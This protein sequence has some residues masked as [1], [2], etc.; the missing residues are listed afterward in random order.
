MPQSCTTK[1][2]SRHQVW[3]DGMMG[4]E[5]SLLMMQEGSRAAGPGGGGCGGRTGGQLM[6]CVHP[7]GAL[8]LR[9]PS[10]RRHPHQLKPTQHVARACLPSHRTRRLDGA[11]FGRLGPALAWRG[12]QRAR[13]AA[14]PAP[15][16]GRPGRPSWASHRW[17]RRR[18][19]GSGVRGAACCGP[20]DPWDHLQDRHQEGQQG[21]LQHPLPAQCQVSAGRAWQRPAPGSP[22]VPP[23][24]QAA[25]IV[26][27]SLLSPHTRSLHRFFACCAQATRFAV[28]L[29]AP[30][31]VLTGH[32]RRAASPVAR[33]ARRPGGRRAASPAAGPAPPP[34]PSRRRSS[35]ASTTSGRGGAGQGWRLLT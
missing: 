6:G 29:R 22:A 27:A 24:P 16:L 20:G 11:A 35:G 30:P 19:R 33:A 1:S 10:F 31:R 15:D 9:N 8:I 4:R 32:R 23:N 14:R 3:L 25:A 12:V 21:L 17:W 5:R 2:S 34:P 18:R 13:R 28:G 7:A 26:P